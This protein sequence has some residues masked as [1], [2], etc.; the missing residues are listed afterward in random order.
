MNEQDSIVDAVSAY[1]GCTQLLTLKG[2]LKAASQYICSFQGERAQ[3]LRRKLHQCSVQTEP[4]LQR[5]ARCRAQ[6]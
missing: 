3:H 6:L 5:L 1:Q 4:L 2:V